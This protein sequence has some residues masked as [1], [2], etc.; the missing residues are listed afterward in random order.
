MPALDV[1][2]IPMAISPASASHSASYKRRMAMAIAGSLS[3]SL[4]TSLG[5]SLAES[6]S[7]SF[8]RDFDIQNFLFARSPAG[9]GPSPSRD[10]E[11]FAG[12]EDRF[13]KDFTCCGLTLDNLHDLLQHFEECHVHVE[14]DVDEDDDLP[15]EFDGVDD[16]DTD[17]DTDMAPSSS[18]NSTPIGVK[19]NNATDISPPQAIALSEIYSEEYRITNRSSSSAASAFD[20]SIVR[21][22]VSSTSAV[23]KKPK[24]GPL[25]FSS[26]AA[27]P[28]DDIPNTIPYRFEGPTQVVQDF[29]MEDV[30]ASGESAVAVPEH[31][32][33]AGAQDTKAGPGSAFSSASSSPTLTTSSMIAGSQPNSR[34]GTPSIPLLT[35]Q[36]PAT[37][38]AFPIDLT[39]ATM[40]VNP[41]HTFA[42]V[43]VLQT[44]PSTCSE[45]SEDF[46]DV[47]N[48][49]D[50]DIITSSTSSTPN[51]KEK[52]DRPYK[53]KVAGCTKSYKNPGGLKYHM[54]HGHCE[55][56][57]DPEMN[58]IIHKPYQ[59]TVAE[60]GKRYKNLN[61]L[62]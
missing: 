4:G 19:V 27:G 39:G 56:T 53:C 26:F 37:P 20:T 38:T 12:L 33:M 52:D 18:V 7:R 30:T 17:M 2:S 24:N 44:A 31:G 35:V 58:N 22:R 49:G 45:S 6:L 21:K 15:F 43:P 32:M 3:R 61:G 40:V 13:C 25:G 5:R 59:C 62:K 23:L 28:K 47:S 55:D 54:Q 36:G 41:V 42:N 60:C 46:K 9:A 8:G 14:S 1:S 50:K 10:L 48:V 29:D 51:G 11:H 16:M 57:G 34:P